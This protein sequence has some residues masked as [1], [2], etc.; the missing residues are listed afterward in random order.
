MIAIAKSLH[1]TRQCTICGG[2]VLAAVDDRIG[3]SFLD[4]HEKVVVL[5]GVVAA[6][7]NEG[8]HLVARLGISSMMPRS[9][10]CFSMERESRQ[11]RTVKVHQKCTRRV[12]S[13]IEFPVASFCAKKRVSCTR[14]R[15]FSTESICGTNA[16]T[17]VVQL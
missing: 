6:L 4:G 3:E 17:D 9:W 1:S 11:S 13:E 2:I 7:S 12:L 8:E 15:E 16:A 14:A 10:K 5:R